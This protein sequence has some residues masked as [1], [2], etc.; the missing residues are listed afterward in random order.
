MNDTAMTQRPLWVT[1]TLLA[2]SALM[3]VVFIWLG[4]WQ[5]RRLYWKLDLIEAVETRAHGAPAALPGQFDADKHA[6]LRVQTSGSFQQDRALLVK[7]VTEL[8]PGYW[9][10]MPLHSD[11]GLLWVNRG[12]VPPAYKD[13]KHWQAP[14]PSVTGLLRPSV[15]DGT[16]LERNIPAQGRWVSRDTAAMAQASGLPPALPYFLDADHSGPAASWPRGGLTQ[17]H[18]RNPHL[19]Y[20]LTWYAMALLFAAALA[21][22]IHSSRN[23]R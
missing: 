3:L 2:V 23:G 7:A 15:P 5:V 9:V 10:M 17:I 21:Y 11:R 6:Y 4:N 8:G 16:A 12:F 13:P 19:A 14:P 20:A 1:A 22:V 18:F